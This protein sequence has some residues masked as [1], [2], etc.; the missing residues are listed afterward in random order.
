MH[1]HWKAAAAAAVLLMNLSGCTMFAHTYS[2]ESDFKG[3]Q[4]MEV[5]DTTEVVKSYSSLRWRI[6]HMINTHEE[7]AKLLISGYSGDVAAD[8]AA[9]CGSVSTDS[10]YGAYA[11]E[12]ASYDLTQIVSYYEATIQISYKHTVEEL[13][14]V[15][16]VSNNEAFSEAVAQGLANGETYM[17]FKVN[18]GSGDN[19]ALIERTRQACRNHPLLISYQPD[20]TGRVYS[21]NTSQKIY[22]LQ[23]DYGDL[24]SKNAARVQALSIAVT[25]ALRSVPAAG[26]EWMV[27]NA[28]RYISEH[29]V[30]SEESGSTAYD[31]LVGGSADSEGIASAMKALCDRLNLECQ[32]VRG[33]RGKATHYWNIVT[34]D[35]VSYHADV[36]EL[37]EKGGEATLFLNDEEKSADCWW[38][39]SEYP[40]CEGTLSYEEVVSPGAG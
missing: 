25:N 14:K 4:K 9:I 24:G 11:V 15:V 5:D 8:I 23:V 17:V 33:T 13:E 26:P 34:I 35:G 28:A 31:A 30:V 10:A 1:K 29:C 18:N 21:G 40:A 16:T 27:I 7:S 12:Y 22:E 19:D 32:V 38:D 37:L 20:I 36:S 3:S 6:Y 2:S 39:L